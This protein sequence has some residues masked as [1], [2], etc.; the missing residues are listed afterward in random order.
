MIILNSSS[1]TKTFNIGFNGR[2]AVT[3]LSSGAVATYVW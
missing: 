2:K 1:T 3:S